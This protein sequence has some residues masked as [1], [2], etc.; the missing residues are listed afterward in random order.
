ML[1]SGIDSSIIEVLSHGLYDA[2]NNKLKAPLD[3]YTI[4]TLNKDTW[5][6]SKNSESFLNPYSF[7]YEH[8]TALID[9]IYAVMK[10]INPCSDQGMFP[11]N[12]L[13]SKGPYRKAA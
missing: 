5:E 4:D 13:L 6:P 9:H 8:S 3:V 12:Q 2:N 1:S 7:T 11:L 10:G